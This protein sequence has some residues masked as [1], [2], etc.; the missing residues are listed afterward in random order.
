[1]RRSEEVWRAV[2]YRLKLQYDYPNGQLLWVKDF[3][4]PTTVF[5]QA[6]AASVQFHVWNASTISSA[7]HPPV[8]GYTNWWNRN[9]GDRLDASFATGPMSRTEQTVDWTE[10]IRWR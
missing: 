6:N 9:V 7:T 2:G 5:W 3:N 1:M 8:L 4:A 10:T